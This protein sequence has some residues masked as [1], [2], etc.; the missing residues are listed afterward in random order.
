[1][2]MPSPA[3][4]TRLR[5]IALVGAGSGIGG[6]HPGAALAPAWLRRNGLVDGLA[7]REILAAWSAIVEIDHRRASDQVSA[8]AGAAGLLSATVSDSVACGNPF[9]VIG[10]DHSC[11]IGTWS[12]AARALRARGPLG[13]IW[14]D[15]HL[16]SHV[17]ETTP[18]GR[19]HGMPLAT[20][21]GHGHPLLTAIVGNRA[22]VSPHHVAIVGARSYEPEEVALLDRLGVRVFYMD[23]VARRGL[24]PVMEDA[25]R[26]ALD[27][28]VAA[29]ISIDLDALDPDDVPAVSTPEPGGLSA[30]ELIRAMRRFACDPRFI[31]CDIVEFNPEMRGAEKSARVIEDLLAAF[32]GRQP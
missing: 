24:G 5:T 28:T 16:D 25:A 13:L 1:M 10:G 30:A 31:G 18:S 29:G 32:Y 15:A 11:V 7:A 12:G 14:V 4:L 20:L 17:P 21:M 26:I 23:E 3:V 9:T 19:Y 27:G 2:D 6:A 22:A 8:I